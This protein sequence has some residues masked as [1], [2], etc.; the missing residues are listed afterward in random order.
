VFVPSRLVH[1][2]LRLFALVATLKRNIFKSFFK[3]KQ[4]VQYL[5]ILLFLNFLK[6]HSN[7]GKDVKTCSDRGLTSMP[8]Y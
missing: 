2:L 6:V 8:F 5:A 1:F 3:V 7:V 4:T